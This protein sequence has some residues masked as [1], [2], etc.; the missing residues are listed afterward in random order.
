MGGIK[1]FKTVAINT[2]GEKIEFF[3]LYYILKTRNGFFKGI[4]CKN[5][6]IL[7]IEYKTKNE[8]KNPKNIFNLYWE[9]NI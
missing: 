3:K 1:K 2:R 5:A 9:I 8:N 6:E 7:R 4:W